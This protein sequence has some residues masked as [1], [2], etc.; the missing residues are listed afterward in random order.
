MDH[1][2]LGFK[3]ILE[4]EEDRKTDGDFFVTDWADSLTHEA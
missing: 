4:L 1:C 3:K 2:V